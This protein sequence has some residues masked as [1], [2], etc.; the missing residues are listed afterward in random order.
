MFTRIKV[1][2]FIVASLIGASACQN[3]ADRIKVHELEVKAPQTVGIGEQF[4]VFLNEDAS[5]D[6]LEI[7][8]EQPQSTSTDQKQL[9]YNFTHAGSKKLTIRA[10]TRDGESK[11]QKLDYEIVETLQHAMDSY[12]QGLEF[13]RGDLYESK[14]QYG[15]SGLRKLT[16]PGMKTVK[17]ISL[18]PDYFGE[19]LTILDSTIYQITWRE[20]VCFLYNT[21]LKGKGMLQI[22]VNEGWGISNDGTSLYISDGS[23]RLYRLDSKMKLLDSREVY[24]GTGP[25]NQLNELEYVNGHIYANVYQSF[26]VARIDYESGAVDA[27]LDLSA[28]RTHLT[29]PDAEVMNG[30]AYLPARAL[31]LITGKYWDKAFL[32]RVITH[33]S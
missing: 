17:E 25:L 13:Y 27:Y 28:L 31:I 12:T 7:T 10:F 5:I 24:A 18:A 33:A 20:K 3:A 15:E 1:P 22:P 26:Q 2:A 6:S 23:H 32:I 30:I 8:G 21:N 29:K 14:G 19:G 16:F 4:T 9:T 11:P